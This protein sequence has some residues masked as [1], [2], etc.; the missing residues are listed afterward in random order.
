[1]EIRE[2]SKELCNRCQNLPIGE[3]RSFIIEPPVDNPLILQTLILGISDGGL[4]AKVKENT[5]TV[6]A[7]D[8]QTRHYRIVE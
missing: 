2:L 4:A 1:M 7:I 3:S 6:T 8:K 5:V